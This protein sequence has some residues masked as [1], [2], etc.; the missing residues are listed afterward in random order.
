MRQWTSPDAGLPFAFCADESGA[1]ARAEGKTWS[2]TGTCVEQ[3]VWKR[4]G[5]STVKLAGAV[6]GGQRWATLPLWT[7]SCFFR[8]GASLMTTGPPMSLDEALPVEIDLSAG[9]G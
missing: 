5:A 2:G 8:S 3:L 9:D 4:Y 6:L 1:E 7:R